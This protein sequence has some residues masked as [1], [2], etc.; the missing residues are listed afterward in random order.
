[1]HDLSFIN[2]DEQAVLLPWMNYI[3]LARPVSRI[4]GDQLLFGFENGFGASVVR[5]GTSYGAGSGRFELTVITFK[6]DNPANFQLVYHTDV[7]DDVLG[8]LTIDDVVRHLA[9][10]QQ[11]T[12][13]GKLLT[14]GNGEEE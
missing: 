7:T 4:R 6:N 10:V 12:P 14:D 11:L 2:S 8:W 3:V 13:E 5:G 1:M 9:Q